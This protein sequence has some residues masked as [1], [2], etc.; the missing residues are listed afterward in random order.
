L[1]RIAPRIGEVLPSP[2]DAECGPGPDQGQYRLY[3]G[4]LFL[5]WVGAIDG[6]ETSKEAETVAAALEMLHNSSLVHDDILDEHS[7]RRGQPTL[8]G[9]VGRNCAVLA[10]DTL[11][12]G[13]L[14]VLAGIEAS[15]ISGVI[16]RVADAMTTMIAGQTN[17]EPDVWA[18]AT[19]R[20]QH[21]LRVCLQKLAIGNSSSS[22][23]AFW[24][25]REDLE[26]RVRSIMDEFSIV[27]QIIN[28][29][30]DLLDFAGYHEIT[31][32]GRRPGE[33]SSRKPTLPLIWAGVDAPENIRDLDALYERAKIEIER[34]KRAALA[35]LERL[36][37]F[38]EFAC[39]L[40]DFFLSPS[41]PDS[42]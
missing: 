6:P 10:G 26:G 13:S 30:G 27:S 19:N 22:L 17:D 18:R 28:D 32:S 7:L 39:V 42:G 34:R 8:F 36:E 25:G 21:W 15:R 29:F 35:A 31:V 38:P 41:L 1:T 3:P 23:A 20:E 16:A 9:R 12:A 2:I 14:A 4:A 5:L 33:E 37:L 40:A 11:I 24:C